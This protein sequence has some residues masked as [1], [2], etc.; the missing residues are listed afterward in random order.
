[1]R[2]DQGYLHDFQVYFSEEEGDFKGTILEQVSECD[3]PEV[4]AALCK[5]TV[6]SYAGLID[7]DVARL[8][9]G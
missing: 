4:E 2:D 1:M 9:F 7:A 6:V 3:I 5:S 8:S